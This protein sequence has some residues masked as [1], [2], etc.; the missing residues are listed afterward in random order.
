MT[1]TIAIL[2]PVYKNSRNLKICLE[3]ILSQT[4]LPD[5]ILI[6]DDCP[7]SPVKN[8]IEEYFNKYSIKYILNEEN[9]GRTKNYRKLLEICNSDYVLMLDGDDMIIDIHF[10]SDAKKIISEH[11]IAL[12]TGRCQN[13]YSDQLVLVNKIHNKIGIVNGR[14]YV[15]KWNQSRNILPHSSTIFDREKAIDLNAYTLDILNTDI[16]ALRLIALS[17]EIYISNKVYSQWNFTGENASLTSD[18][19]EFVNNFQYILLPYRTSIG[20]REGKLVYLKIWITNATFVY[21]GTVAN[22]VF[23]NDDFLL[24]YYE[25]LKNF[26][27]KYS[28]HNPIILIGVLTYLPKLLL[29]A[30]VRGFTKSMY[31]T[32]MMKRKNYLSYNK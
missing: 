16:L 3:S 11:D 5:E 4:I 32:L 19:T 13:R 15:F 20:S 10:I 27:K 29:I 23:K 28:R 24:L 30:C 31:F 26:I 25:F 18:I 1:N 7:I 17:G 2:I 21:L 22:S 6:C 8:D 14:D 12:L 9:I